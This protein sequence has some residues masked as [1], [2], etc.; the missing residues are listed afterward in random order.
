MSEEI[1]PSQLR[2]LTELFRELGA[3]EPETWAR[4]QLEEGLPQLAVFSFARAIWEAV[5]KDGDDG[6]IENEVE[7][8]K[9]HSNEPCSQAGSALEEM[10]ARGV[11]RQAI[12]NLVRVCQFNA[13]YHVCALIDGA[14]LV[15]LPVNR[16]TLFQ[17]DEFGQP[18]AVIQGLHEILLS[19]DPTG[20]EMRPSN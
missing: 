8:S 14:R 17:V 12:I 4:S 19:M 9:K 20:R 7:W 11:N 10:L 6:W 5:V 3:I 13:L 16:W 1:D 2:E 18:L 15:E